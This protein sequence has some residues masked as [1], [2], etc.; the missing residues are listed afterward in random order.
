MALRR[1][2]DMFKCAHRDF[3]QLGGWLGGAAGTDTGSDKGGTTGTMTTTPG[4]K[5]DDAAGISDEVAT[6]GGAET[7]TG[8]AN[9]GCTA[10]Q[11]YNAATSACVSK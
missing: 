1:V 10:A 2:A 11:R 7:A 6:P 3:R 5:S 8:G 4:A 9:H